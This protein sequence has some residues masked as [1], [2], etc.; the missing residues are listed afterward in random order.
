[1]VK[2]IDRLTLDDLDQPLMRY[3]WSL[4]SNNKILPVIFLFDRIPDLNLQ[5]RNYCE[6]AFTQKFGY[7]PPFIEEDDI[8]HYQYVVYGI[9][10]DTALVHGSYIDS[11]ISLYSDDDFDPEILPTE[12]WNGAHFDSETLVLTLNYLPHYAQ[13]IEYDFAS[14]S[15]I[16]ELY[17]AL[18]RGCHPQHGINNAYTYDIL[19]GM[20]NVE[21]WRQMFDVCMIYGGKV[22][23]D[24]IGLFIDNFRTI[25]EIGADDY[26]IIAVLINTLVDYGLDL[27]LPIGTY[28]DYIV[29]ETNYQQSIFQYIQS[30]FNEAK[31]H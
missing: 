16:R 12:F 3:I 21:V 15:N 2:V 10:L 1:M 29:T 28:Q 9:N 25:V 30:V 11:A 17:Q 6:S 23:P 5:Y 8:L 14:F 18:I 27:N 24:V 26:N 31:V 19:M 22:T 4:L 13:I 20:T 7:L